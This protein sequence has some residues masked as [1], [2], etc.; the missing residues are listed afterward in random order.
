MASTSQVSTAQGPRGIYKLE[1]VTP[2]IIEGAQ[3]SWFSDDGGSPREIGAFVGRSVI[4]GLGSQFTGSIP[5]EMEV[6]VRQFL[7]NVD[8]VQ[9]EANRRHF[10]RLDFILRDRGTGAILTT[11]EG[12]ILDLV[13]L[14]GDTAAVALN[15]GRTPDVR[16]AERIELAAEYWAAELSCEN[17]VCPNAP[18]VAATSTP[19]TPIADATPV[20]DTDDGVLKNVEDYLKPEPAVT[21]SAPEPAVVTPESKPVV[22]AAAPEPIDVDT[23]Q[24]EDDGVKADATFYPTPSEPSALPQNELLR[25]KPVVDPV[26]PNVDGVVLEI[27]NLAATWDGEETTGG[28]WIAMPYIPAYRR[29]VITNPANG[30]TIEANLFWRD[31]NSSSGSTLLSSEAAAALGVTPGD[32]SKLGVKILAVE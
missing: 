5:I 2:V 26:N 23:V 11:A 16:I 9:S 12:L 24:A 18:I 22:I 17:T 6:R 30:R 29:A 21:A 31:P 3:V 15:A 32:I 10:V 20:Q 13:A 7:P 27:A 28:A 1:K 25:K 4:H 19:A 8:A 14:N